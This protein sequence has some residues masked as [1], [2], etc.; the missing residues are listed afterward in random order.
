MHEKFPRA[1]STSRGAWQQGEER[2]VQMLLLLMGA[3]CEGASADESVAAATGFR[4]ALPERGE[5]DLDGG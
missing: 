2:G 5:G 3:R 4:G 1:G